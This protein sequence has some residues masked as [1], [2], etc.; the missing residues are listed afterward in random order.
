MEIDRNYISKSLTKHVI[1]YL[2]QASTNP[3]VTDILSPEI[4]AII[5]LL[6][7]EFE[8]I[9]T[10]ELSNEENRILSKYKIDPDKLFKVN[11][12]HQAKDILNEIYEDLEHY[13]SKSKREVLSTHANEK[14]VHILQ[15]VQNQLK[16]ILPKI[17][18]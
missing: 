8:G 9:E 5:D 4:E 2:N 6:D 15:E 16:T 17:C 14:D 18:Y 10:Y 1:N 3:P 12:S 11:H 7:T 13:I